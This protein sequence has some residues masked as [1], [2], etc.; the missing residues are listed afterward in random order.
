VRKSTAVSAALLVTTV[1]AFGGGGMLAFAGRDDDDDHDRSSPTAFAIVRGPGGI[2]GIVRFR[3]EPCPG[4]PAPDPAGG[5]REYKN[6][7]TPEVRVF[8]RVRGLPP[9]AH[10]FHIHENGS[11]DPTFAAA[12]SHY[13]P[14]HPGDAANAD[15]PWHMG[16]LPNLIANRA[17]RATLTHGSSRFT[18]SPSETSLFDPPPATGG[19]PGSAVVIHAEPDQGRSGLAGGDRI[20]C[21]VIQSGDLGRDD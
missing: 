21:G 4:C 7:P 12:G 16:D 17:G 19:G 10:G 3:Q 1:L 8:A 20:A 18:L 14:S 13:D 2:E 5:A 11:C 6:F 9:G 15:H